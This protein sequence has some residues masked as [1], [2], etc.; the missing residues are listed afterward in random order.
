MTKR[1]SSHKILIQKKL[2][3]K[4]LFVF[5]RLN[6]IIHDYQME[7]NSIETRMNDH[8]K[9]TMSELAKFKKTS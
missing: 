9:S 7:V 4:E 8:Q 3:G 1:P 2:E 5:P 6:A